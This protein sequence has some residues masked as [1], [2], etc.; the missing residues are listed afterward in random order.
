MF[1]I[2]RRATLLCIGAKRHAAPVALA[3]LVAGTAAIRFWAGRRL[4]VP[5]IS[6]D[7]SIYALLGR[8]IWGGSSLLDATTAGYALAYPAL[9]GLPLQLGDLRDGLAAA[10]A[11]GAL[12]MSATAVVVYLWGRSLVGAWWALC[13]AALTL[14]LPELA[15]SGF[16]MSEVAVYPTAALA[17]WAVASAL[18]RPSL[19]RQGLAA[20]AILL[21]VAT[22]VRSLALVPALAVAVGLQC[23]FARS[24][25]PARRLAPLL[26]AIGA[27]VALTVVGFA[28]AGSW[29]E[30]FGAYSSAT[31][32]YA[33]GAAAKGVA[34][35]FAGVFLLVAG[36]PLIALAAMV[37]ECARGR[38][39]DPAATALVA[40]TAAWTACLV[41]EV[42]VFASRWAPGHVV[43]RDLLATVPPLLLV[44]ALWLARGL[45][46]PAPAIHIAALA[47]AAPAV[48]LPVKRIASQEAALDAF[49][50]IPL[51]RF[52]EATSRSTLE[53][54]YVLAVAALVGAAVFIPRRFRLVLPAAVALALVSLAV[55]STRELDRL[56]RAE[57][58]WVFDVGD[59]RWIDAAAGGDVTFLQAGT[60]LSTSFWKHA[61]WNR[62]LS[63]VAYLPDAAPVGPADATVVHLRPSGILETDGGGALAGRLLVAPADLELIGARVAQ[64]PRS[65]DLTGLTL[66][67]VGGPVRVSSWA[68]GRQ[69]NGDILG[70][71]T[72]SVYGCGPGR[73]ELTLIGKQGLPVELRADGIL[74]RRVTVRPGA[75][76]NGGIDA[77]PDADGSRRCVFTVTSPGLVG[78]TR[79]S[80]VRA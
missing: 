69:P 38:E 2:R 5:W 55:L 22:H 74:Q 78:S 21:A 25:E 53:L 75:V 13:A 44:F 30:V 66:W 24:L 34:W 15:Y 63:A 65:T 73:L 72:L 48:L 23:A 18:T 39:L 41:L 70:E 29:D 49:T 9:I 16:L 79:F 51:W 8:S 12:L 60:T 33:L 20:A 71:A 45:P 19:A 59:P 56:T 43:L 36:I 17:L 47:V 1:S 62:R 61:F 3:V 26:A 57:R 64:A 4:D 10:Q 31:G 46:R 58:E 32:G 42:G 67:R 68:A 14:A 27:A 52:G 54:V 76:W 50:L 35:H 80:F 28:V 37:I 40:T 6:P 77:P 7:E 11:L